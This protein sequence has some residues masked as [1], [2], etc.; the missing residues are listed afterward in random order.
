[1]TSLHQ[2]GVSKEPLI[3]GAHPF[4]SPHSGQIEFG[5]GGAAAGLGMIEPAR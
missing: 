1:M 3:A 5:F 2:H 4:G